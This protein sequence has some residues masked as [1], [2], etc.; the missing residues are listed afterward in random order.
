MRM[1][2]SY[3]DK[4]TEKL[5]NGRHSRRLPQTIQ[6]RARMR[7]DRINAAADIED[8]RTPPSHHLESLSGDRRGQHSIRISDQW[9]VCFEWRDGHAH[10]VEIVDYH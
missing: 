1:I 9:R 3:R 5:A 7:L 6:R 4:E 8:L 10:E 2:K